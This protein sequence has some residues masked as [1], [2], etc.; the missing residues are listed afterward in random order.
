[1]SPVPAPHAA[2]PHSIAAR[3]DG[4]GGVIRAYPAPDDH[5]PTGDAASEQDVVAAVTFAR[6]RGLKIAVR[7][8]GHS[9]CGSPLREGGLLLDLSQLRELSID[10]ASCT[11]TLQPGVTSRELASALA[12]HELEVDGVEATWPTP[13]AATAATQRGPFTVRTTARLHLQG[14]S[15]RMKG[16]EPSTFCM[17]SRRS[18][19][20]SYIREQP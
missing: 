20:L 6:S 2:Q 15:E 19:Q 8:S 3:S 18:S 4:H 14:L 9:W 1:M 13:D 16:L 11:A 5:E 10:P 7:A 12:E 17:A